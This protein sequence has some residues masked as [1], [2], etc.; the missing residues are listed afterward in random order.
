[1]LHKTQHGVWAV[2]DQE[3]KYVPLLKIE[4]AQARSMHD[5]AMADWETALV[6]EK[7][8]P[9][10]SMQWNA[11]F[12]LAYDGLHALA[13]SLLL[14]YKVKAKT[15]ECVFAYLC[16]KHADLRFDWNFL[17]QLRILRNR[18]VY[19]GSP[20]S[21]DQWKAVQLQLKLCVKALSKAVQEKLNEPV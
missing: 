18:S 17:E 11:V 20:V 4:V 16:E 8:A 21:F 3:G 9:R 10:E 15:H 6:L 13:E 14:L 2:C 1:M 7:N 5:L 12:K 19:Y